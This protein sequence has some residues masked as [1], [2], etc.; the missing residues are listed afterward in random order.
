VSLATRTEVHASRATRVE[1]FEAVVIGA[2]QAGL[3]AAYHLAE[4][5][6]DFAVFTNEATIGD[7]WRRRWDTLRLFTPARYSGLPGMPFPAPPGHFPDRDEVAA[8]LER[9]AERFDLPVRLG[10]HVQRL[11]AG[12]DRFQ[13]TIDGTDCIIQTSS[14][15]VATG[16]ARSPNIPPIAAALSP[17]IRQLHSSEYHNPFELP[18]GPV[19]VVGAGNSG[20]QIALELAR[21]RKVWLA[22]RDVGHVPRQIL[23]R[24]VFDWAWPLMTYATTDTAVGK[25][26]RSS[27]NGQGDAL[28]GISARDLARAGVTRVPRLDT[29]RRG[30]PVCGGEV[31]DPRVIIWCTGFSPNFQWIDLPI[32]DAE[33][34]PRHRRGVCDEAPG[35]HFVGLRFQYRETSSL[36][37]GVGRD[38]AFVAQRIAARC[39]EALNE[40][41]TADVRG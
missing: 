23:G 34:N 16:A 11:S 26:R 18:E 6:V 15:I 2:G 27:V 10:S 17:S 13:L 38:A 7:N 4:H 14:V 24:D 20:A 31:L 35:L 32:F 41:S 8:Y 9:Y 3:A 22:G 5:D 21:S 25:L 37:G 39:E 19:L 33:G 1:Q 36:I 29:H 28:I 40:K 30:S 12:G